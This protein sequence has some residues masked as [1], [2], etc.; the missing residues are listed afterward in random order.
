M[1]TPIRCYD[2]FCGGGGSSRGATL[3]GAEVVGGLDRWHLAADTFLLNFPGADVTREKAETPDLKHLKARVGQVDLL[4]ASPEC[5]SHSVAK[6]KAPRCEVSRA[7]AFQ[8]VRY[9]EVFEPRWIVVENVTRMQT[10]PRFAEWRQAVEGL[11]Y[12]THVCVL[13]SQD[14]RTPQARRR[15]FV[16]CDREQTPTSPPKSR[17]PKPQVDA[18]LGRGHPRGRPWAFRPI[19]PGVQADATLQRVRRAIEAFGPKA[20]FIIVYYGSDGAGGYQAINRPLRTITTLDRFAYVRPTADGHEMR[21]L[22][23]PE[24]AAAMGFPPDH[25]WPDVSRRDRIKLIGNAVCP[26]V[27]CAVVR[28][29][30]RP[31]HV[32]PAEP[33]PEARPAHPM[34]VLSG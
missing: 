22:Q 1:T 18:V 5:T 10:W 2:I 7:T 27:M 21:M 23:P 16:L 13:D 8:V 12:K 19:N 26:Q 24:L 31:T 15:L 32:S 34:L 20:E 14:Y 33:S 30:T 29:L 11:G 4:L 6:G 17:G 25:Q 3:A 9:A 28:H